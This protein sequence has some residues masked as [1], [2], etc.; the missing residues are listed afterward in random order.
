[1]LKELQFGD[2]NQITLICD[3]QAALH[4]SSNAVF[5]ERNKY[6]EIDC[7]FIRVKIMSGDIKTKFV[8]SSD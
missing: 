7:H 1:L 4:I 8:N 3:N 6:I 5:H 2:V